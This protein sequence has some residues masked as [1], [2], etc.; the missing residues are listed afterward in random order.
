M[1]RLDPWLLAGLALCGV[2]LF[3]AFYGD[4]I[5]PHEPI[6]SALNV[7][8]RAPYPLPPGDP[9][10]FGSD[11]AGRDLLSIVLYG[12]RTTLGIVVLAGLARLALGAAFA[13]MASVGP[14]RAAL[15]ALADVVSSIPSTIVAVLVVLV[16][17]GLEAP[18]LV[19]I[20]AL[21]V[22]GWAGPY[23]V[24]RSELARLRAALFTEGARALGVP[25]REILLRHHLPHLVPVLALAGSQQVAAALVALAELGVVGVFVGA[26][27][28]LNLTNSLNLVRVGERAGGF[29]SESSEWSAMLASGRSIENLY[30]TR[31]VILVP[32]IAIAFAVLAVSMFGIGLARHY[33]RR[34]LLD[35]LRPARLVALVAILVAVILPAYLLPDHD[36][37]A[38][39]ASRDARAQTAIGA[40]ATAALVGAGLG[41]ATFERTATLLKQLAPGTV[42]VTGPA[43]RV[44]LSEGPSL[45]AVLAGRS[46]GGV[47]DAPLVFA[48]W[49]LSPADFPPQHLSAFAAPDFGTAIN[50]WEDDYQKVDVR[51][52]VTVILRLAQLRQG[53]RFFTAPGPDQLVAKAILHGAAAVILIDNFR[54]SPG[55]GGPSLRVYQR[56]GVEDPIS[57]A[58][59]I[60]TFVLTPDA[61]DSL[62]AP[63]GLS[64]TDILRSVNSDLSRAYTNGVSIATVLPEG[65]HVELPVARVNETA[66]S[67]VALSPP[68]PDGHRLVLWAVAPSTIDG[69]RGAADSLAAVLRGMSGGAPRGLAFVF[70]DP[71]GDVDANAK[72]IAAA[73]GEKIDLVVVLDSLGGQAL[74]SMTIYDD[75]FLPIDHY[76]D[77]AGAPHTR[78]IGESEPDWPTGLSALGRFKYVLVR[79]TGSPREDLDLRPDAAALVAFTI[80]RYVGETS[81][82]HQ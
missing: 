10:I 11:P 3:I 18:A 23:R 71:H 54:V 39:N 77:E 5:A 62:L 44:E 47:V 34:N 9:F 6:F 51:G 76:A 7:P 46:S 41:P 73:L 28:S 45:L 49:G 53:T 8:D 22:T 13:S 74:R 38:R 63:A 37:A 64:A 72:E 35:D 14:V 32:G 30:V 1:R 40:D 70:F 61:A 19:F 81:E 16:F 25:R 66:R 78:T 2:L 75:L 12:A 20:G 60:P 59:G 15:D 67:L 31:W 58:V 65:A 50:T 52:K 56:M 21:L 29:V 17:S 26:V 69:S 82:L 24:V 27:R 55:F 68:R 43:G 42:T 80:A 79:G 36:A 48:G 57:S 4:R 33:R